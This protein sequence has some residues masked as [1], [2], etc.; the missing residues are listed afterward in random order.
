M[1]HWPHEPSMAKKLECGDWII[2]TFK[3]KNNIIT[4]N[5]PAQF[6]YSR[7]HIRDTKSGKSDT[8]SLSK[9]QKASRQ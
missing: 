8:F 3:D 7:S 1:F 4:V 5:P 9:F 6:F 2:R